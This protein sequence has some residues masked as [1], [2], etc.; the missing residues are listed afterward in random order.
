M[1]KT[2]IDG[3]FRVF[4]GISVRMREKKLN[5][6]CSRV[7]AEAPVDEGMLGTADADLLVDSA[8]C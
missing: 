8:V 5:V 7:Q 1:K 6:V 4:W 3:V 2:H